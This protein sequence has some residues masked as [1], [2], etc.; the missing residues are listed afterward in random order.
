MTKIGDLLPEDERR[1]LAARQYT[2]GCVLYLMCG[3]TD[4]PKE[5]FVVMAAPGDPPLLLIVNS[6]V[7]EF[8]NARPHLRDCQVLLRSGEHAFLRYDSF[9]NCSETIDAMTLEEI[10]TQVV[11]DHSRIK[12]EL[13]ATARSEVV[14]AIRRARTVSADHKRRIFA[15]LP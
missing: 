6:D 12:G 11:A 5:K 15:V 8:I 4:P 7:S 13:S 2:A 14:Q 9:L 3:F 10:I 1:K